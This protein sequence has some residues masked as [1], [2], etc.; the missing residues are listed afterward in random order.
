MEE[1]TCFEC[2]KSLSDNEINTEFG[3]HLCNNCA[4]I[5]SKYMNGIETEKPSN[6]PNN[7]QTIYTTET[8]KASNSTNNTK[9]T[10]FENNINANFWVRFLKTLTI[11]A[12]IIFLI[13]SLA[14][15]I[16]VGYNS[17]SFGWGLL[18]FLGLAFIS[19][20]S[21]SFTM[22]FLHLAEDVSIIRKSIT[23]NK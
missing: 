12:L 22:V 11:I 21:V 20:L 2:G 14:G 18:V 3:I 6:K 1:K 16:F 10:Y 13:A 7:N 9:T 5:Y 8:K 15:G 4:L 23:K 19:F 17:D